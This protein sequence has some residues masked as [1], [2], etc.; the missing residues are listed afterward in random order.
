[1]LPSSW[2]QREIQTQR[3]EHL[4]RVAARR[5]AVGPLRRGLRRRKA[6]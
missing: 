1:M 3:Y 6:V 4:R 5:R 2:Y